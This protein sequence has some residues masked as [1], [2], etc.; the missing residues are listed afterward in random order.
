MVCPDSEVTMSP[1][2]VALPSGMFS[3]AGMMTVRLIGSA[4]FAAA[5]AG[6]MYG[7]WDSAEEAARHMAPGCEMVYHPNSEH[8]AVYDRLYSEYRRL[9]DYFGR[10]ENDVMKRLSALKRDAGREH[11]G[12]W[13]D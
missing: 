7:G 3:A 11:E 13:H 5:A 6:S 12:A 4:I 2:R 10:G 9:Y 1:G 8:G